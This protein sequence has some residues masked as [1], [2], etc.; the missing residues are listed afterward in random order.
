MTSRRARIPKSAGRSPYVIV[1]PGC[2]PYR[3]Y[4]RRRQ[5]PPEACVKLR[6]T[7]RVLVFDEGD[8]GLCATSAALDPTTGART[9]RPP[10]RSSA[11]RRAWAGR[12]GAARISPYGPGLSAHIRGN[13]GDGAG[14]TPHPAPNQCPGST[15]GT[16]AAPHHAPQTRPRSARDAT[17]IGPTR[18]GSLFHC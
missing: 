4:V 5:E 9:C 10:A 16:Q 15:T 7:R 3:N 8:D 12:L 6:Q 11:T 17:R 18:A 13:H 14:L 1:E 2:R